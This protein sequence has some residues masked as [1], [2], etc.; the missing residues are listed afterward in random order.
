MTQKKVTKAAN[1]AAVQEL[2]RLPDG[3]Q[4]IEYA[5]DYLISIDGAEPNKLSR[6]WHEAL[7]IQLT[8]NRRHSSQRNKIISVY[9]LYAKLFTNP[10]VSLNAMINRQIVTPKWLPLDITDPAAYKWDEATQMPLRV[11]P[12]ADTPP[13]TEK[14]KG[15]SAEDK[16]HAALGVL[17]FAAEGGPASPMQ[18]RAALVT[19]VRTLDTGNGEEVR[20]VVAAMR[21][22][23]TLNNANAS[24]VNVEA[25][26]V[27]VLGS[28]NARDS[29]TWL[30]PDLRYPG[31]Y[32]FTPKYDSASDKTST[33]RRDIE[34]EAV[35]LPTAAVESQAAIV[36]TSETNVEFSSLHLMDLF[37]F[38]HPCS[39]PQL[40]VKVG[41]RSAIVGVSLVP[42]STNLCSA[43]SDASL[44]KIKLK[45]DT[46]V[47][48]VAQ[49]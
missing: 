19:V 29:A 38:A 48:R 16:W 3:R 14:K 45:H 47:Q 27:G 31:K 1:A 28:L 12:Y 39:A 34:R 21:A 20:I 2:L 24:P 10:V 18:L 5:R 46:P 17:H 23:V 15:M 43:G 35:G 37:Y 40:A 33:P 42:G 9:R 44:V 26:V 32:T 4:R 36:M 30:P 41:K 11:A 49:S 7:T 25:F 6:L 8:D 22:W 13:V